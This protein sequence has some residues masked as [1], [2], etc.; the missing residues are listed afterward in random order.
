MCTKIESGVTKKYSYFIRTWAA[1]TNNQES[2]TGGWALSYI[3]MKF[4]AHDKT[5]YWCF[6]ETDVE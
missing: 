6:G 4:Y 1:S 3:K 5:V 2:A